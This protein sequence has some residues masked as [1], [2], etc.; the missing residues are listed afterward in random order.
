MYTKVYGC[1]CWWSSCTCVY[2]LIRCSVMWLYDFIYDCAEGLSTYTLFAFCQALSC[3]KVTFCPIRRY[4]LDKRLT[5]YTWHSTP[6]M[7][8]YIYNGGLYMKRFAAFIASALL[9]GLGQCFYGHLWWALLFFVSTC[10]LGPVCNILAALH[11]LF[12]KD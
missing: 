9:P 7:V 1:V 4:F 3:V 12:I 10:M 11:I 6:E 2:F 8:Y 5:S